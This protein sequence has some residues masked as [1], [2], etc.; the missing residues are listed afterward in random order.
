MDIK[1]EYLSASDSQDEIGHCVVSED[2]V[3]WTDA[4]RC[5]SL[6][7]QILRGREYLDFGEVGLI[8]RN[9]AR[10]QRQMFNCRVCANIKV[11]QRSV[12]QTS[13]PAIGQKTLASQESG[14][15]GK[16]IS[17]VKVAG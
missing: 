12:S 13:A 14:F 11:R 4:I 7:Q 17:L 2:C 6:L 8:A 10:Q 16:W 15:P 9:V 5:S 3:A 1:V